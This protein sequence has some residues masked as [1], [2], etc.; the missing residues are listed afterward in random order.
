MERTD[1]AAGLRLEALYVYPVKALRGIALPQARVTP[2][3]LAGDREWMIVRPDGRFVSQ[4]E[5]PALATIA[6]RF[7]DGQL[8][9]QAEGHAPL[10]VAGDGE[11]PALGA[12]VWADACEVL[13]AGADA[14]RWLDAVL[15]PPWPLRLV[16]MRPGFTRRLAK[17]DRMLPGTTTHF[18]DAAPVL[19][20][21]LASL[22]ALNAA[23]A[24]A[25][26]DA[27][28]I[29]RFRPNVVIDGL[30]PFAEQGIARI[31][32]A[33]GAFR[34][35]YPCERC[36]VITIDQR[37]GVRDRMHYEP[38]RTLAKLNTMPGRPGSPAF[39]MNA[40]W[41]GE[42]AHVRVGEELVA[43]PA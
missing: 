41:E 28:G 36:V 19:V 4:R 26:R 18:A 32:A 20:V 40:V 21:N 43:T 17:E 14:G 29:E 6:A 33:G 13:D 2:R 22:R 3:G 24:D 10:H 39:G 34:L 9:L 25:D 38:F 27:V 30:A 5:L 16:R 1:S 15:A 7:G 12:T 8:V 35:C 23:L 42:G 37:S 31:A 11:T